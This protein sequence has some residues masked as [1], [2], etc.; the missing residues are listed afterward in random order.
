[1]RERVKGGRRSCWR[2]LV[3]V[4]LPGKMVEVAELREKEENRR[5][6]EKKP[7]KMLT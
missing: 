2:W 1:M 4:L 7:P 5:G 6:R 3:G